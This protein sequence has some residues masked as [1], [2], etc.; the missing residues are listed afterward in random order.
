MDLTP[1]TPGQSEEPLQAR[2]DRQVVLTLVKTM[3]KL[4][5]QKGS[6]FWPEG[7]SSFSR[8]EDE[9]RMLVTERNRDTG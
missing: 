5:V 8:K 3:P 7:K 9:V 1:V 4:K 6:G 2:M